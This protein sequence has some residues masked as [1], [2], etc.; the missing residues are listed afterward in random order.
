M[1]ELTNP[2]IL[3]KYGHEHQKKDLPEFAKTLP[4]IPEF[5]NYDDRKWVEKYNGIV[6][7]YLHEKINISALKGTLDVLLNF[8]TYSRPYMWIWGVRLIYSRN[9]I[10]IYI[11]LPEDCK[12]S[13]EVFF[14][15]MND[16]LKQWMTYYQKLVPLKVYMENY[17]SREDY[18]DSDDFEQWIEVAV[19]VPERQ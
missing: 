13:K 1:I 12:E 11:T 4:K 6:S 14:R 7:E 5:P 15:G 3:S 19:A 2:D 18:E 9:A 17:E 10:E 8:S 16:Y